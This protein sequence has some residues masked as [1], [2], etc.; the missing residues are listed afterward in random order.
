MLNRGERVD[1]PQVM[2]LKTGQE[3]RLVVADGEFAALRVLSSDALP[4]GFDLERTWRAAES[5][6]QAQT[7][8]A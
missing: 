3:P 4:G 8:S 2:R 6:R 5:L 7:K 1:R